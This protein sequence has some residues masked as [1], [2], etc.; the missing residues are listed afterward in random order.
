MFASYLGTF[1]VGLAVGAAG[2]YCAEKFTD[3]RREREE[4]GREKRA[5]D[6][7]AARMP[8]LFKEMKA[9]LQGEQTGL[10][11]EFFVLPTPGSAHGWAEK[12]FRYDISRFEGLLEKIKMLEHAGFVLDVSRSRNVPRYWLEESFVVLLRKWKR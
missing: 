11:R 9:D 3:R 10:V 1:L 2:T 12:H 4:R 8:E 7:L 5:F 6:D